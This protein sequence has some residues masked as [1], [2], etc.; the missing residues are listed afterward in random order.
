PNNVV[1]DDDRDAAMLAR[2]ASAGQANGARLW[3]QINH[4]GRQSP[5]RLTGVPVAP[6]SVPMKG[7]FGVFAP[8]RALVG[9]EIEAL[10]GK[11]AT[12]ARGARDAGFAGVELHAAHGYL[13]SQFLS[14]RTNRRDDGWGGDAERRARFL[15]EIVRAVRAAVG[16]AFPIGVKL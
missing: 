12:T 15:L 1:V 16:P 2:W 6:S 8:P 14:A 3:M 7:F 5:R 13:I 11:F 4:A 10:V 9:A